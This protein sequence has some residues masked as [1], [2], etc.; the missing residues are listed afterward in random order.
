MV[1][2]SAGHM[3][4]QQQQQEAQ[5]AG[6]PCRGTAK[7]AAAVLPAAGALRPLPTAGLQRH[8]TRTY[9]RRHAQPLQALA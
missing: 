4:R 1:K 3:R 6:R 2:H 5:Q 8:N 7:M 9:T